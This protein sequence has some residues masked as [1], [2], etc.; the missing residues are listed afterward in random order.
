MSTVRQTGATLWVEGSE[1]ANLMRIEEHHIS[2]VE[3]LE[4]SIAGS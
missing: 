2:Q 3:N 1:K 4:N